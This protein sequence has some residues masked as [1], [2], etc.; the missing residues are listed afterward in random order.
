M[1]ARILRALF[2]AG[3]LYLRATAKRAG[4]SKE[5]AGG[6]GTFPSVDRVL[7][8]RIVTT[9]YITLI[10]STHSPRSGRNRP[11]MNMIFA[12]FS[13][14]AAAAGSSPL[15]TVTTVAGEG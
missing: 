5:E 10:A 14:E 11:M 7:Y 3:T 12:Q 8:R 6:R 9:L 4:R 13:A 2:A 1:R 15:T